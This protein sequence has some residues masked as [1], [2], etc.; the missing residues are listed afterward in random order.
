VVVVVAAE[1]RTDRHSFKSGE[2]GEGIGPSRRAPGRLLV[3]RRR[4]R[5]VVVLLSI[6]GALCFSTVVGEVS[7]VHVGEL[8]AILSS[9]LFSAQS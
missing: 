2:F 8:Q 3:A 6:F 9:L 5:T 1:Q 7:T 4:M